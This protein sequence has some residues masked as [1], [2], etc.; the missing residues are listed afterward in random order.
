MAVK[1]FFVHRLPAGMAE[2]GGKLLARRQLAVVVDPKSFISC[3]DVKSLAGWS[4]SVTKT[5][6]AAETAVAKAEPNSTKGRKATAAVE[7]FQ[8]LAQKLARL[9]EWLGSFVECGGVIIKRASGEE[10]VIE[11]RRVGV[12]LHAR[13]GTG[14]GEVDWMPALANNH[15]HNARPLRR[16]RVEL[17]AD[18]CKRMVLRLADDDGCE[19][20]FSRPLGDGVVAADSAMV[21]CVRRG[22]SAFKAFLQSPR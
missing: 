14:G 16:R 7:E 12:P 13:V 2:E 5:L 3:D 18:G 4:D 8:P 1:C 15:Q 9:T 6:A 21:Y 11:S 22:W 20:V 19:V 17:D 10:D